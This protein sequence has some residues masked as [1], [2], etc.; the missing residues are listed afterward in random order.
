[1]SKK[2]LIVYAS[3][4][5]NTEKVAFKFKETFEKQGWSS[6]IFKI[7]RQKDSLSKLPGNINDYDFACFGSGVELHQPYKE[8]ISAI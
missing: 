4:T 8:I 1:M 5:K 2:S 7:N 6:D 3:R